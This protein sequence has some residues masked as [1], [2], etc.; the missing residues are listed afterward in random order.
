MGKTEK[1]KFNRLKIIILSVIILLLFLTGYSIG[2]ETANAV[3]SAEGE[4]AEPIL[5]VDNNPEIEITAQQNQGYYY[6]KV[7]NYQEEN[8]SEV[9]MNYNI[10]IIGDVD[11][12]IVFTLYKGEEKVLLEDRKTKEILI[13]KNEKQEHSYCL[14]IEYDKQKN[15]FLS[16]IME[17]IQIKVHAEQQNYQEG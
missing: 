12:A 6:F 16:D 2:K 4:I 5:I 13:R 1:N 11:D 9:D 7:R 14:K 8:I 15:I 17:E 3:I 10:E